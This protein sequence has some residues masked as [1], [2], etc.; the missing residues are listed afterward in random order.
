MKDRGNGAIFF[1]ALALL[2]FVSY[3]FYNF[4][5]RDRL[6]LVREDL[7]NDSI[8]FE[9]YTDFR[10]RDSFLTVGDS[11][12]NARYDNIRNRVRLLERRVTVLEDAVDSIR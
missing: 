11:V 7:R 8:I 1:G 10:Y 6:N 3:L 2:L 12:T 5:K 4:Y 9:E